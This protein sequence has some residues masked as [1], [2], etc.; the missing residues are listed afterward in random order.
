MTAY[1]AKKKA[2]FDEGQ[3]A[4]KG[5][6]EAAEDVRAVFAGAEA[7]KCERLP[8]STSRIHDAEAKGCWWYG[9][10]DDVVVVGVPDDPEVIDPIDDD[11]D[12]EDDGR[13]DENGNPGPIA[14]RGANP[15]VA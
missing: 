13:N 4:N 15:K 5:S 7:S 14:V 2:L 11:D 1:F 3:E 12:D 6:P 10:S 8:S 9:S